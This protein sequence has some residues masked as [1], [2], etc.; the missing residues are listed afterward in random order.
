MS[1]QFEL[2][3]GEK[4]MKI[5]LMLVCFVVA[6]LTLAATGSPKL[7]LD[8]KSD[9]TNKASINNF[10]YK[11]ESL[12]KQEE[13]D[14]ARDKRLLSSQDF[15]L[16]VDFGKK[17]VR[18]IF[19]RVGNLGNLSFLSLRNVFSQIDKRQLM[20]LESTSTVVLGKS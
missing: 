9:P 16:G 13:K 2:E 11:T 1:H 14:N 5:Q 6:T 17:I 3:S 19:G 4:T 18:S 15:A 7:E 12:L 8:Y 20:V 10:F